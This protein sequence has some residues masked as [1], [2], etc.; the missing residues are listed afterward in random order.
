M[1]MASRR[2]SRSIHRPGFGNRLRSEG[3]KATAKK[4]SAR[5][6]PKPANTSRAPAAGSSRA[7]PS[8]APRNGPAQGVATKAARNLG[9][10]YRKCIQS[11]SRNCRRT[12]SSVHT[13]RG[14]FDLVNKFKVDYAD[15]AVSSWQSRESGLRLLHLDYEGE[16]VLHLGPHRFL[17]YRNS[18][19]S[20][21]LLCCCHR[22][23]RP[24][25]LYT[26]LSDRM[27]SF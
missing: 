20:E 16:P 2:C 26:P 11:S 3:M 19:L 21:R 13:K 12:M 5:P 23:Y 22:K 1:G 8:A 6:R 25:F 9:L 14:N 27:V 10:S 7:V 15:I 24:F 18:T 4:G 17:P